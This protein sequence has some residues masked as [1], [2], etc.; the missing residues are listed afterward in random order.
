MV[1]LAIAVVKNEL[2]PILRVRRSP[3]GDGSTKGRVSMVMER[4]TVPVPLLRLTTITIPYDN[5]VIVLLN[6]ILVVHAL[7]RRTGRY[8]YI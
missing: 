8:Q 7:A 2:S 5:R 1:T 3:P 4:G 6:L